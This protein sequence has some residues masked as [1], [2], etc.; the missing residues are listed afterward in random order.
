MCGATASEIV[1]WFLLVAGRSKND[2]LAQVPKA[3]PAQFIPDGG[4][5]PQRTNN[6]RGWG[7]QPYETS[8]RR[9]CSGARNAGRAPPTPGRLVGARTGN[10]S[11]SRSKTIVR[12]HPS[13][14]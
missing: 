13:S 10:D 8:G 2:A 9:F 14:S 5:V 12:R 1:M 6:E 3:I 7:L 11:P 4:Q